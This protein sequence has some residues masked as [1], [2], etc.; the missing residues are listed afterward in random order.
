MSAPR[1]LLDESLP[2]RLLPALAEAFPG[3]DHVRHLRGCGVPDRLL[4][5]LALAGEFVLV[6]RDEDY[7][8]WSVLRGVP[9]KVVWLN[10]G[11]S[12]HAVVAA[13]LQSHGPDIE[14][15]AAHDE[16]SFLAVGFYTAAS[17]RVKEQRLAAGALGQSI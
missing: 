16:H 13:L 1:L 10:V 6:T 9:P 17:T 2:E 14:L 15:F 12:R 5:D 3:S 4:W 8:G 7:L 11:H